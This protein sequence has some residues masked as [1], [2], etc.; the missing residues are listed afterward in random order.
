M[1]LAG[2]ELIF[3][4][5]AHV[6]LFWIF[7]GNSGDTIPMFLLLQSSACTEPRMSLLF[8]QSCQPA[9]WACA[10]SWELGGTQPGQLALTDQ[11]D[12]PHHME[13]CSVIKPGGKK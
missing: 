6:M 1:V 10:W 3:F 8:V 9:G 7:D 11:R 13:L 5:E 2:I 12:V 4:T